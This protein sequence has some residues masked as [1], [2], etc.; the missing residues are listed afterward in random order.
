MAATTRCPQCDALTGEGVEW[1]TQCYADLRPPVPGPAAVPGPAEVPGPAVPPRH[2]VSGGDD[3]PPGWPCP[4]C[5][6]VNDL[7]AGACSSCGSGFLADLAADRGFPAV[8]AL[9]GMP[10]GL[11]IGAALVA[12]VVVLLLLGGVFWLAA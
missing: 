1:C 10:R 5:G 11:R 3:P 7:A 9:T 12:V 6:T 4:R 8:P 2:R